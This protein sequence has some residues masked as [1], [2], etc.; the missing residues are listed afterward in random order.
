MSYRN[1]LIKGKMAELGETV[2]SLSKK[3]GLSA[4]TI[5][6]ARQAGNLSVETLR[7]IADA[8]DLPMSDLFKEKVA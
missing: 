2:E 5:S 7:Q 8:L 4:F 3:T 1:D 6:R